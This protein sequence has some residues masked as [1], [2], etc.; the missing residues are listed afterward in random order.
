MNTWYQYLVIM[1][2]RC[3]VAAMFTC[4]HSV[5][6]ALII[7]C[8]ITIASI[9]IML[10]FEIPCTLYVTYTIP[11][12]DVSSVLLSWN[13]R[14]D[15]QASSSAYFSSTVRFDASLATLELSGLNTITWYCG[16]HTHT[17]IH[18]HNLNEVQSLH[19][20]LNMLMRDAE[21]RKKEA[22][23][24]IRF[25]TCTECA[26]SSTVQTH[27]HSHN[28][29]IDRHHLPYHGNHNPRHRNRNRKYRKGIH[30]KGLSFCISY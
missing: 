27:T 6:W 12:H 22:S 24:V 28:S 10:T 16:V 29:L 21:G 14:P 17:H 11:V 25:C 26:M 5:H 2:I 9:V 1:T 19:A 15:I 18:I 23:K 8:A 3:N 4:T 7:V 30:R 13:S 20:I